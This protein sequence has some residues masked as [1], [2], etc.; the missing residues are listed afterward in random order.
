MEPVEIATLHEAHPQ[1]RAQDFRSPLVRRL[2][3]GSNYCDGACSLSDSFR[4]PGIAEPTQRTLNLSWA[5]LKSDFEQVT[6][7]YQEP[8]ITEFATLGLAC[9]LVAERAGL[10]VTEVTRR[11]ER[12]DYWLGDRE[13]LLEVSGQQVGDIDALCREKADQLLDNPFE[14]PGY[15]CVASYDRPSARLWFYEEGEGA[16]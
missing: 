11:G 14:K 9:I 4:A 6:K 5:G 15:V 1:I 10:E 7:T 2:I 16:G 8:V 13:L 12:A 3:K